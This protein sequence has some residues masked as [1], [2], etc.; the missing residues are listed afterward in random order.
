MNFPEPLTPLVNHLWQSTLFA[1]VASVLAVLLRKNHAQTRY[2]LWLAASL[3]FL[4]PFS[5]LVMAGRQVE[6][7]HAPVIVQPLSAAV[8]QIGQPFAPAAIAETAVTPAAIP[9][10][11]I[12]LAVWLAGAIFILAR[13]SVRWRRIHE[14]RQAAAP[15]PIAGPVPVLSSPGLIEP[16]IFGV[17]RPVL[18]L[19]AGIAERLTP[20]QL[21]AILAHEL[22]HVRRRDNLA[23]AI[24][25]IVEAVFWF[26]PLVWWLGARMVEERERAC[27]EEVLRQGAAPEV[28][29]EGILNVC[30]HYLESP[31]VCASG[32]TG[33]NL[34]KRIEQILDASLSQRL[35]LAR[36]LMLAAAGVAAIAVPL[37]IGVL[38]AQSKPGDPAF[39][40]A[41]VKPGDP[42]ARGMR[43]RVAPGGGLNAEN[44]NLR[45]LITLAYDIQDFQLAGAPGWVD[46][47]RFTIIAKG[48]AT[49]AGAP[50]E[51]S[52]REEADLIKARL[53][54]LLADRFQL[55]V[56]KELKD[57]PVYA[58]V[59]A[60]NGHR[61]KP[62]AGPHGGLGSIPG[63]MT[64]E[65]APMQALVHMLGVALGRPVVDETGLTGVYDFKLEWTPDAVSPGPN[66]KPGSPAA[67]KAE[68]AGIH[69]PDPNGP[70]IF[71]A[72]QEQL[73][74]R[75]ESKKAP[76]ETVVI[77]RVGRPSG[78]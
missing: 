30:R 66:F 58:L 46:T 67:Q 41:S 5:L 69:L 19:P 38:H 21:H 59:Q 73:G 45:Q 32:V 16:G 61:M 14:A 76:V 8:E 43:I 40:V 72:L 57:A 51:L 3:K 36:K 48:P 37:L 28:Y 10:A 26:H 20:A 12:L 15:L 64:G 17:F 25:M 54:T 33:A 71:N 74:L 13:W 49:P 78:N 42:D 47:G 68:E 18:L 52:Q 44:V 35:T 2:R 53:R 62:A 29:A 9:W 6:W 39:E 77:E 50:Q 23:A 7:R 65:G 22:C 11:S 31:L 4:V 55:Q 27:D 24:H 60:K 70:S 34:K 1:G 75:L 63:Q 56:R